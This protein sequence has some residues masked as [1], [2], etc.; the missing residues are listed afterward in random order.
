[1]PER[2][3]LMKKVFGNVAKFTWK[4][5]SKVL[6]SEISQILSRDIVCNAS[7]VDH[8]YWAVK[9]SS[10]IERWEL[11]CLVAVS[12]ASAEDRN[13]TLGDEPPVNFADLGLALS[14]RLL[15]KALGY[16]WVA[17]HITEDYLWLLDITRKD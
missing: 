12:G 6:S 17:F 14:E 7:P 10:R 9:L 3:K 13:E 8:N 1:M 15:M 4:E 11:D 5:I 2:K 16:S